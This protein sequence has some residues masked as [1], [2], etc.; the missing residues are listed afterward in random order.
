MAR[1]GE[2]RRASPLTDMR[3]LFVAEYLIDFNA[4]RAALAAGYSEK[5]A[6]TQ[7]SLLL[8]VPAVRAAIDKGMAEMMERAKLTQDDVI[9]EIRR[10]AFFDP[11]K[12]FDADGAPLPITELD[13]DTAAAV[14]GLE[15]LDEYEGK[16]LEREKV[17]VVK[18]YKIADKVRSLELLARHFGLLNDK[19]AVQT[20]GKITFYLPEN[21]R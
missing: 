6:R 13:D 4:A 7:G 17:A 12:L 21:G 19:L 3:A 14:A 11:R 16:G 8:T 2:A 15:V 20:S 9:A 18:K 5:T 10:L 1:R